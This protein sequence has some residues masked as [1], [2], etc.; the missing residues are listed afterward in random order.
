MARAGWGDVESD[1]R[2]IPGDLRR[3]EAGE[4]GGGSEPKWPLP[5]LSTNKRLGWRCDQGSGVGSLDPGTWGWQGVWMVL[6]PRGPE[7]SMT[8]DGL[9]LQQR[10]GPMV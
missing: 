8:E 9:K 3:T 10:V 4:P 7:P 5:T 6:P 2:C 1:G